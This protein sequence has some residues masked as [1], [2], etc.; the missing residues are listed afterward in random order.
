F[1]GP[2]R[3]DVDGALALTGATLVGD[4]AAQAMAV[5]DLRLTGAQPLG[6]GTV[7]AAG[8]ADVGLPLAPD[9]AAPHPYVTVCYV[10]ANHNGARDAAELVVLAARCGT[11]QAG[12]LRLSADSQGHPGGGLLAVGDA[13]VGKADAPLPAGAGFAF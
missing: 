8:D 9:A 13:D 6:A 10:D 4:A 5:G 1:G 12:D 2:Y 3:L 11:L 7:A